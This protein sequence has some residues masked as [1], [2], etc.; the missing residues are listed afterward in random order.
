VNRAGFQK[1]AEMRLD[2][3]KTLLDQGKWPAAYYL[4]GYSVE[5]ALKACIIAF[6]NKSDEWPERDFSK[7]CWTHALD[8]LLKLAR[9]Q[10]ELETV[11]K[12]D[13]VFANNWAVAK[14]W[15]EKARYN[16][17]KAESDAK[18]LY[19]AIAEANH[20]VLTWLKN[21]W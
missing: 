18:P 11:A 19:D 14:D 13:A 20:G 17:D 6:L 10:E 4:A 2:D 5:C 12:K 21:Y 9:L 7:N 15:T 8:D 3:A 16:L 1:L